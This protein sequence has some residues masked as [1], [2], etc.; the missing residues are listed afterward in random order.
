MLHC[1]GK[2]LGTF[3]AKDINSKVVV[4]WKKPLSALL[5]YFTY[6]PK[7]HSEEV[8]IVQ[9]SAKTQAAQVLWLVDWGP[10]TKHTLKWDGSCFAKSLVVVQNF[11]SENLAQKIKYRIFWMMQRV[12]R[13]MCSIS[14][15]LL[16]VKQSCWKQVSYKRS[17]VSGGFGFWF[18]FLAA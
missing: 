3:I 10:F 17:I 8:S 15:D 18:F 2:Y 14:I 12:G 16:K 1:S 13:T 6:M 11:W 9:R 7:I 4:H 5:S